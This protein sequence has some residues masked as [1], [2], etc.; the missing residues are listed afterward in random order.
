MKLLR[1]L[2]IGILACVVIVVL[3]LIFLPN[4]LGC[5]VNSKIAAIKAEGQPVCAA[6]LAGPKIPDLENAAVIYQRVFR[7]MSKP[8]VHTRRRS[9]T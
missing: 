8:S 9:E 3:A 2:G 4:I 6:D 7:E 5:L 1:V